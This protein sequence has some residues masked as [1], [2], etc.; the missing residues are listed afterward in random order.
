ESLPPGSYTLRARFVFQ[1]GEV[2][3]D[4]FALDVLPRPRTT[5]LPPARVALYDPKGETAALLKA[6]RVAF[7]PIEADAD[8]RPFKL[9]IVGKGALTVDGPAP[10]IERVNEG[11]RV[12]VF[13]QAARALER[14]LGFRTVE[15]GL[16]QVYP[17]VP[18]H[19]LLT[20]LTAVH[21]HDWRG[22][23]TLVP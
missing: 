8:M 16:R 3:E 21:L 1:D 11:L 14:R 20:G 23:A 4:Q 7:E 10:R 15:Y 19:A 2:Q 6:L 5:P 13:E 17:R 9:L 12:L 22:E 18:D